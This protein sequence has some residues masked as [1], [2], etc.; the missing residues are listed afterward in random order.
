MK[1]KNANMVLKIYLEK[2]FDRVEWF[3]I[4]DT[5]KYLIFQVYHQDLHIMH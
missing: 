1:G 5:R 2:A 4:R 3:F